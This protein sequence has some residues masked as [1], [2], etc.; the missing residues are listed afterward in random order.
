MHSI[1]ILLKCLY[2]ADT[3]EKAEILT[4]NGKYPPSPPPP[5][6][7]SVAHVSRVSLAH[8]FQPCMKEGLGVERRLK[9][10]V[11]LGITLISG[12]S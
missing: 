8:V 2:F 12:R 7:L 6:K 11:T 10:R 5:I 1:L 9:D 4:L 3:A